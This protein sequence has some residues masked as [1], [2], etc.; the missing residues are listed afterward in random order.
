MTLPREVGIRGEKLDSEDL[1][2]DFHDIETALRDSVEPFSGRTMNGI[3]P[4]DEILPTAERVAELVGL[5]IS[6]VLA[7]GVTLAWVSV[8][9]APGC[10]ARWYP[11]NPELESSQ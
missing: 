11:V 7:P 4:F 8:E 9:E 10:I 2:V 1:L 5:K 3:P 6:P